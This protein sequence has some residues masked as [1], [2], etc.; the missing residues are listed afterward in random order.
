VFFDYYGCFITNSA[1]AECR[2]PHSISESTLLAFIF[3]L[4]RQMLCCFLC[5]SKHF[6]RRS[7]SLMRNPILKLFG[8]MESPVGFASHSRGPVR[9]GLWLGSIAGSIEREISMRTKVTYISLL[10]RWDP[11]HMRDPA[12]K[13]KCCVPGPS[14]MFKNRSG[15]NSVGD[16]NR[17]TS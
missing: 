16:L 14:A 11:V 1:V 17:S 12:P 9:M 8:S 10:A 4:N 15:K 2:Q 7:L 13:A 3:H 6:L 5:C